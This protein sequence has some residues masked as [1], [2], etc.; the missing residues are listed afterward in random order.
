[1]NQK[2]VGSV[3]KDDSDGNRNGKKAI[4]Q[5]FCSYMTFLCLFFFFFFFFFLAVTA[6]IRHE[7]AQ[8]HVCRGREHKRTTFLLFS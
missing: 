1:M 2:I 5:Q 4:K 6:R 7:N 8:F 3:S